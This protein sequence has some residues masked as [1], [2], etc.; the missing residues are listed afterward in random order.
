MIITIWIFAVLCALSC[1][2][3]VASL[4]VVRR[5]MTPMLIFGAL[6]FLF[7]IPVQ[8]IALLIGE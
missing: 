8:I 2:G 4:F 6:L 1:I 5:T 7:N 3:F